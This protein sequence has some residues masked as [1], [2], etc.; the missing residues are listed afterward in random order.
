ML[1]EGQSLGINQGCPTLHTRGWARMATVLCILMAS[2]EIFMISEVASMQAAVLSGIEIAT[3]SCPIFLR[4][5]SSPKTRPSIR[6]KVSSQAR[7]PDPS[8]AAS[9]TPS[10]LFSAQQPLDSTMGAKP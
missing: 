5:L 6:V 10:H 8:A 3:Q 4:G 1:W 2:E 7:L 9:D